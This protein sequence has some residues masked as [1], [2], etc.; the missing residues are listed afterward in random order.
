VSVE[1][2]GQLTVQLTQRRS[3]TKHDITRLVYRTL[4]ILVEILITEDELFTFHYFNE[5]A[6]VNVLITFPAFSETNDGT[7]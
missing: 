6:G 4:V 2:L 1:V 5:G 7:H 3:S